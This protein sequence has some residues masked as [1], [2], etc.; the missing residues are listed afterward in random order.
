M[1]TRRTTSL[2]ALAS[3]CGLAQSV[4]AQCPPD[5]PGN[6]SASKD[7]C[8]QVLV[9]WSPAAG[10]NE[11]FVYRDGTW[12]GTSL[13]TSFT[14][15]LAPAET[16]CA[17]WV[18]SHHILCLPGN[19]QSG[20]S[21][22]DYG[23]KKESPYAP[24]SVQASDGTVCGGVRLT[25][26]QE[27]QV[28]SDVENYTIYRNTIDLYLT[29]SSVGT[30][31][32]G[33]RSFIDFNAAPGTNYYYWVRAENSC[34]NTASSHAL[35]YVPTSG[36]PPAG[37]NCSG[38][39]PVIAGGT[40]TGNTD[41]ATPDGPGGCGYDQTRDVWFRFTAASAGTL[42]ADNCGGSN[43]FASSISIFTNGCPAT[44][45]T[46]IACASVNCNGRFSSV[47]VPVTPGTYLIRL[48]GYSSLDFGD[49]ELHTGFTA[50]SC[51][52]NCDGSTAPPILNVNDF[53]CF[54]NKYAA[55]DPWANCDG[56]TTAPILNVNDFQCF[57]NKFAAGCS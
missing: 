41:C 19:A 46:R 44:A 33:A 27:T 23:W 12:I 26:S 31:A 51:Y 11:Y 38:A 29:S 2:T 55:H 49:Y 43:N 47:D 37:D 45:A 24:T 20:P 13:T 30:A 56:S 25:W 3:L 42:H 40:Y 14:D 32:P 36:S 53:Q 35:G 4:I 52:A 22:Y 16:E 34:G 28:G 1:F 17:Y 6:L 9:S 8:G 7:R 54:L 10:A 5:S 21:N 57:L 39:L 48:A 50:S 18:T 15:L